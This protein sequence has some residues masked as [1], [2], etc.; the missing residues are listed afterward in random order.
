MERDNTAKDAVL[1]TIKGTHEQFV[2]II[3]KLLKHAGQDDVGGEFSRATL[4]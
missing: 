4:L 2:D 3:R 1:E